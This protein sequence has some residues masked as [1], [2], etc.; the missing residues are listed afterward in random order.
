MAR[1]STYLNFSRST[2]AAFRFTNPFS[3][4]IF[5]RLSL[6][7]RIFRHNR[8]SRLLPTRTRNWSCTSLCP[9]WE[10]MY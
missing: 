1:V 4:L 8:G 5:P 3:V 7:S 9:F 10:D 2:E 6:A